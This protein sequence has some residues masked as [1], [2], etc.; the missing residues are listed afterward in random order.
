MS[1]APPPYPA[2][3]ACVLLSSTD[4]LRL[5]GF[6]KDTINAVN[7]TVK[8]AWGRGIQR[9]GLYEGTW[10]WKLSGNPWY[11]QGSEAISARRLIIHVLTTLSSE[12]WILHASCDLTKKAR[13]KDTMFFRAAPHVHRIFFSISFNESDKVRIIDSPSDAVTAAFTAAIQTWSYGIQESRMKEPDTFQMKLRKNPWWTSDG[14]QVVRSKLLACN[15][16]SAMDNAGYELVGSVDM[17]YGAGDTAPDLDTWF[18]AS[19]VPATSTTAAPA[20]TP[21]PPLPQKN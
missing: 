14:E 15:I 20:Y 5:C 17:S 8:R 19:K 12:G 18:F 7:E 6:T 21:A 4:K 3:F 16:L 2:V 10:E 13:D 11:G 1:G 9:Q